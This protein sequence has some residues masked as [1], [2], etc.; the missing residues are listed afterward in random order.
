MKIGFFVDV[1]F[2]MVDG[3]VNVVDQYARQLSKHHEVIVFAPKPG[4]R[5]YVDEFP[6]EVIRVF[7]IQVPNTDYHLAIPPLDS[8]LN[9]RLADIDLDIVHIHSP[10]SMGELG[11]MYAKKNGKPLFATL[12]SQ[13]KQDFELRLKLK[14]ITELMLKDI[15]KR[16]NKCDQTFTVNQTILNVYK[17]YGLKKIP[18]IIPNATE[19]TYLMGQEHKASLVQTLHMS[20]NVFNMLFVGR[21]DKIKNITFILK[22][23]KELHTMSM[24]FHMYFVG[25]G[26]DIEY[27]QSYVVSN[28]LKDKV[29]FTGAIYDRNRLAAMYESAD[30]FVFPSLYDTNSLVQ[31]EAASQKT[32]TIFIK[33]AATAHHIIDNVNGYLEENNPKKFAKR[34]EDIASHPIENTMIGEKAY[35]TIYHQ[36]EDS[37]SMLLKYYEEAL[38]DHHE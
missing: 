17:S 37:V 9:R 3:V 38:E 2:P 31:L 24:P 23:L 5:K 6:Y 26:P 12:H 14:P 35:E 15:I 10:F 28:A 8:K 25:H 36:W 7:K 22:T 18:K 16:L 19:M 20:S 34:I 1:F 33:D 29:T 32:P 27:F 30:L 4:N 13:Y 11:V 21:I